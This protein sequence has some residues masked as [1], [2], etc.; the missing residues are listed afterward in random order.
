MLCW[1]Q[2][3][4]YVAFYTCLENHSVPLLWLSICTLAWYFIPKVRSCFL[5]LKTL[6]TA[7]KQIISTTYSVLKSQQ[8][9]DILLCHVPEVSLSKEKEAEFRNPCFVERVSS[10]FSSVW[11]VHV[12]LNMHD[13]QDQHNCRITTMHL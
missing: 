6:P 2:L 10:R 8:G 5:A 7:L 12:L 4:L 11:C 1:V 3:G 13:S 9:V